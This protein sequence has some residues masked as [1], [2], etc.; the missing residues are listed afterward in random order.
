MSSFSAVPLVKVVVP[1]FI[2]YK[3]IPF[4]TGVPTSWIIVIVIISIATISWVIVSSKLPPSTIVIYSILLIIGCIMGWLQ[5]PKYCRPSHYTKYDGY[6]KR[7]IGIGQVKS[8]P[9]NT[10]FGK[11][12][13]VDLEAT[14][15]NG[16]C[17]SM[18]GRVILNAAAHAG[19]D[20]IQPGSR[21]GFIVQL[22][23]PNSVWFPGGFDWKEHLRK[24]GI[25]HEGWIQKDQWFI[26]NEPQGI[27]RMS[28]QLRERLTGTLVK[29][30]PD[31]NQLGIAAALLMGNEDFLL[32]ETEDKFATAGVLHVLCVSGMHLVLLYGILSGMLKPFMH[33]SGKSRH[34]VFPLLLSL[35][36]FYALFTGLSPSITRAASMT[37]FMILCQWMQKRA[38]VTNMLAASCLLLFCLEPDVFSSSG[39][40]LSFLAVCG[41]FYI[42]PLLDDLW[43]PRN[44]I[45]KWLLDLVTVTL[46]A[47]IATTPLSLYL[48]GQFPNWFLMANM[49]IV[50]L[51]TMVMY[52][53][54]ALVAFSNIPMVG[55]IAA[56]ANV[57]NLDM[58]CNTIDFFARLP[59]AITSGI[60]FDGFKLAF[61]YLALISL[62]LTFKKPHF[63]NIYISLFCI[64]LLLGVF[65]AAE[66]F[67]TQPKHQF[68]ATVNNKPILV[69]KNHQMAHVIHPAGLKSESMKSVKDILNAKHNIRRI[70]Y[71]PFLG[72]HV[73]IQSHGLLLITD[74]DK[75]I[76][77]NQEDVRALN[78][79]TLV[80][81]GRSSIRL[82][83]MIESLPNLEWVILKNPS[84]F[85]TYE[86]DWLKE[87]G[88]RDFSLQHAGYYSLKL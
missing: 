17:H 33:Q 87:K 11:R 70:K 56:W 64:C 83:K 25:F 18:T 13:E 7:M 10:S 32:K 73:F 39:F 16:R 42:K 37:T 19:L 22:K 52:G 26:L 20:A 1:L 2:G 43:H 82:K 38:E 86:R 63:L 51:S 21:M 27:L 85:S 3:L 6:Q 66:L 54:M 78:V 24:K 57:F 30:I 74:C 31:T 65:L 69:I 68:I 79:K 55:A 23:A 80:I 75:E 41:I 60:H 76:L 77:F 58:L 49:I 15:Y 34:F 88:I 44:R 29:H 67:I 9:T 53:T 47:Q 45:S 8:H 62:W 4:F 14:I 72:T 28:N 81:M 35:I 12:I 50:P 48:F 61:A 46:A 59:Y 84:Y 36:W 5:H 40:Q 71:T